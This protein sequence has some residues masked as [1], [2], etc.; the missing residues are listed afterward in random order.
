MKQSQLY[1]YFAITNKS[2]KPKEAITKDNKTRNQRQTKQKIKNVLKNSYKKNGNVLK[3][4]KAFYNY[5]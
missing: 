3:N 4:I 1:E 5:S 2:G